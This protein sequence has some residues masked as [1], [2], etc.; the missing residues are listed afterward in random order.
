MR[1]L[2]RKISY[3]LALWIL[4][5]CAWAAPVAPKTVLLISSN[6][7]FGF[8]HRLEA[9]LYTQSSSRP[10]LIHEVIDKTDSPIALS[11]IN[12]ADFIVTMG[13]QAFEAALATQTQRPIYCVLV[14]RHLFF[15]LLEQYKRRTDDPKAPISALYLDQPFP[16]QFRLI[17]MLFSQ[18]RQIPVGILMQSNTSDKADPIPSTQTP[19]GIALLTAYMNEYENQSAGLEELLSESRVLLALPESGLYNA[20]T[21]RGIL[22]TA[23][24]NRVPVIAYSRTFVN[25]GALAAVYSTPKQVAKQT[26][27]VITRILNQEGVQLPSPSFPDAFSVAINY[28]VANTL[29]LLVPSES[30]LQKILQDQEGPSHEV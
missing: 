3:C 16:R 8:V 12:H 14:R 29:G 10:K 18:E 7:H 26:A 4:C 9:L 2:S 20:K 23:Y 1:H 11:Q 25:N 13:A 17:K 5:I 19:K 6:S 24:H 28:Q 15:Q 27:Q 22:L 30:A 21:A